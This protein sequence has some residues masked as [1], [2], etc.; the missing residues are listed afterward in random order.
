MPGSYNNLWPTF[1]SFENIYHAF[2]AA[3]K[4][5]R[6]RWESLQYSADLEI[7]I[8]TLINN[9]EWE[10]YG[11]KPY[12]QFY[13]KEPKRRLISAPSFED[14]VVHHALVQI[15]ET[16]FENRFI[17]E[18]YAC[19]PGRGTH[20][21]FHHIKDCAKKARGKWGAYYVLKCDILKYFYS[22]DH[23]VLKSI[24]SRVIYDKKLLRLIYKIIQ[25]Y[26]P[27]EQDGKGIPIGAL[28]SQLFAN[29]Y[30]DPLDHFIKEDC[31]TG[32][33]ARYMDDFVIIHK[34]KEYL[35]ELLCKIENFLHDRL[36]LNLNPKTGIFPGRHGIG[37]CGYRIW[38]THI[39]PR[40]STVKRAKRRFKKFAQGYKDDPSILDHA[41]ASLQSF[42]GY[43]KHCNGYRTTMAVLEKLVFKGRE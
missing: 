11:P 6:Y 18:T 9:L 21:A 38:P 26:E 35:S 2:R 10:M 40:K 30:L 37:F 13:I 32:F 27:A 3:G 17:A 20:A 41:K 29:I 19:I 1:I 16:L 42:L 25:S 14:R 34:D 5:K 31:R 36:K 33:Y 7:K 15:I 23:A 43:M 22:V 24:I 8:I 4:G 12:R 28:T 39:K